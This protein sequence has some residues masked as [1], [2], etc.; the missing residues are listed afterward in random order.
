MYA[1]TT[2]F[3]SL[4]TRTALHEVWLRNQ[5][6][7]ATAECTEMNSS[8]CH[9][10]SLGDSLHYNVFK[11]GHTTLLKI[12]FVDRT[13]DSHTRRMSNVAGVCRRRCRLQ[14]KEIRI[15]DTCM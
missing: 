5:P 8:F 6:D 11:L 7:I 3:L 15:G 12:P 1:S 10:V 4:E 2:F 14:R 13:L 9:I